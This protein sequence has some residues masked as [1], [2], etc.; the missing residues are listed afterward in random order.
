M[1]DS[2]KSGS[3]LEGVRRKWSPVNG[4]PGSML[5]RKF[6]NEEFGGKVG[7]GLCRV[8][9]ALAPPVSETRNVNGGVRASS[10]PFSAKM[11]PIAYIPNPPRITKSFEENDH[12]ANPMPVSRCGY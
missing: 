12:P 10:S 3:V 5:T 8:A 2:L 7:K 1:V 6:G 4:G 9:A 11:V